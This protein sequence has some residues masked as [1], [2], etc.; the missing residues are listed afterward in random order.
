MPLV[1]LQCFPHH[2]QSDTNTTQKTKWMPRSWPP[3]ATVQ[4]VNKK[5]HTAYT[6]KQQDYYRRRK[7]KCFLSIHYQQ[8]SHNIP[9]Q[10]PLV[11]EDSDRWYLRATTC[12][13]WAGN[14]QDADDPQLVGVAVHVSCVTT[15][16]CCNMSVSI[17]LTTASTWDHIKETVRQ[18]IVSS[19]MIDIL[20][21]VR[22]I[23][24]LFLHIW[25]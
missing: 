22:H 5:K 16:T 13:R 12:V 15:A 3:I 24:F 2:N 18:C 19:S 11:Q 14:K 8:Q 20:L 23:F 25:N 6:E 7:K 1:H 21:C 17:L 4:A 10:A 9:S